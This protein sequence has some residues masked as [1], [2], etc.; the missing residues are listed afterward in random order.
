MSNTFL[1]YDYETFGLNPS[2]DKPAQFASIRTNSK[3]K[4]IE[5]PTVFYCY[6]PK[7]YLP[8]PK[9]VLITG[10]T[11]EYTIK[12]GFNES[13]FSKKI[14]SI[15]NKKS[16]CIV[17][18]NNI[19]FDDEFTR[20]IF[21]RNLLDIYGWQ[22]KNGNSRLDVIK[23]IRACYVF[24]PNKIN[25]PK[26]K[27]GSVS[28]KLEDL[29][30]ANNINHYCAH[31]ALSDVYTTISLLKLVQE[32]YPKMLNFF[33]KIRKKSGLL[34]V[35][36][37]S[38]SKLF[39]HASSFFGFKQYYCNCFFPIVIDPNNKNL[40]IYINVGVKDI[41][42]KFIENRFNLIKSN[43][44]EYFFS[45]GFSFLYM[46][47]CEII[48]P[49]TIL[50]KNDFFRLNLN[51]NIIL[52]NRKWIKNNYFLLKDIVLLFLSKYSFQ[53]N[54][55]EKNVDLLIYRSF[56]SN[57]DKLI[58]ESIHMLPK[59]NWNILKF[60]DNRMNKVFYRY[61]AR[62]YFYLLS[63][64]EQEEWVYYCNSIINQKKF[65]EYIIQIKFFLKYYNYDIKKIILLKN[66]LLYAKR[67]YIK[68]R[69]NLFF[70]KST[71]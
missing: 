43:N 28:F 5:D 21:Y 35:L 56:L 47:R 62:N 37:N 10:I 45:C 16:S 17:G 36:K 40:L 27:D 4:I 61:R 59:K 1:F 46:N 44:I 2:L 53:I 68:H 66:I 29:A 6:P 24:R 69:L 15:L 39:I 19:K 64:S 22:W 18:F 58:L 32:K 51:K 31:D 34:D 25:W 20:N 65:Y 48:A 33:F 57:S 60:E 71:Y 30:R 42:L 8:D 23:I 9:S 13:L 63:R 49:I 67:I 7:D 55:D 70:I 3:F 12:H 41:E 52:K 38:R 14:Y 11:P 54:K 26:N 50:K